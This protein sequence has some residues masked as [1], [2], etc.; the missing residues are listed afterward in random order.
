MRVVSGS[1][2]ASNVVASGLGL[3]LQNIKPTLRRIPAG[4]IFR[5]V[6]FEF[7]Q[8]SPKPDPLSS[9]IVIGVEQIKALFQKAS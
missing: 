3:G 7:D 8:I 5:R 1:S 9:L 6:G 2:L 4:P